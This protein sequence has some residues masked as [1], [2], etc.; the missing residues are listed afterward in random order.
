MYFLILLLKSL[1][2]CA[3]DILIMMMK[4]LY[5]I[6]SDYIDIKQ[7]RDNDSIVT[8]NTSASIIWMTQESYH[9][10]TFCQAE[11]NQITFYHNMCVKRYYS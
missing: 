4:L 3:L 11:W 7:F 5:S 2:T 10:E 8:D 6:I 1:F 9:L